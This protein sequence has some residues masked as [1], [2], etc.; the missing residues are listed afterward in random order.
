MSR[1]AVR[2]RSSA[3]HIS[4]NLQGK[5]GQR[6]MLSFYTASFLTPLAHVVSVGET[7]KDVSPTR[8]GWD[9]A[10]RLWSKEN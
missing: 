4:F 2:V 7:Q 6:K 5:L 10:R 8:N 1:S 9:T 3:L